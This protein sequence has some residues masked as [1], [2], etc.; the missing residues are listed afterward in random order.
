MLDHLKKHWRSWFLAFLIIVV[1]A[2]VVWFSD[3]FQQC[4]NK[5]YYES[6]DYEPEKGIAQVFATLGWTKVCTGEFLKVDGEAITA[7]FTLVVGFFTGAL[8][9]STRALWQVTADTLSH[10]ERTA[11]RQLRAY[12]SVKELSMQPFRGPDVMSIYRDIGLVE[13]PILSYRICAILENTGPTPTRNAVI[14]IN[15]VLRS[16]ELPAD[17]TFPDGESTETAAIGAK[18]I[19]GTP[20]FFISMEQVQQVRAKVRKLY[21]WGWVDYDDVFEDTIRHR[22]EFCFDVTADEMP[23]RGNTYMRF[24]AHGRYNGAD[25][26]CVREP[27]PYQDRASTNPSSATNNAAKATTSP[28]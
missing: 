11:I 28:A 21:F 3:A 9:L 15:H 10:S 20:G 27:R 18:G 26:D 6:A 12:V 16:T 2:G 1:A 4:M 23:D 17:F 13:G 25:G 8:W 7:F 22:T 14:N 5:S 19:F 24:P